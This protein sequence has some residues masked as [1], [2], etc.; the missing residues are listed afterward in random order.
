M[1]ALKETFKDVRDLVVLSIKG[2]GSVGD[3]T[4][5]TTLRKKKIRLQIVKNTL[6]RKV[7]GEMGLGVRSRFPLLERRRPHVAWGTGSIAELSRTLESELKSPRRLRSS[8]TRLPSRA[9][10]ADGQEVTFDRRSRCRPARRRSAQIFGMILGPGSA[11]AGCLTAPAGQIASQIA[12]IAERKEEAPAEAA[13]TDAA[14]AP[15]A[16]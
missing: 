11:I 1:D 12:T 2:L 14:A 5:R 4:L 8:R 13:P 15:T 10:I 9:P 6:T 3:S 7:F 16:S